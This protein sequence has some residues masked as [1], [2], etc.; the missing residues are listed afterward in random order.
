MVVYFQNKTFSIIISFLYGIVL[1]GCNPHDLGST[2]IKGNI[3]FPSADKIYFYSFADSTDIFLENKVAMDSSVIDKNKNYSFSFQLK[4][5]C[6]F[7]LIIGNKNLAT[8]LFISPGDKI[9]INFSGKNN[10]SEI[11]SSGDAGKYNTYLIKYLDAFYKNPKTKEEYYI[12]TNYMDIHHFVLY[13]ESRK[14]EQLVFFNNFFANDE[15]KKDFRDYALNT[16]N[17]GIAVDRLMYLWKKRMKGETVIA[18]SS[19]FSFATPEFIENKSAFNC[20]AYI[21]FLNLY[22][23]DTYERMVDNGELPHDKSTRLIP[24]VE[25]YKL[26][27]RILH[28]PF[29]DVVLFNI[30]FSD[31]HNVTEKNISHALPEIALDSMIVRFNKKYSLN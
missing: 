29:R 23:K 16:I 3:P 26:A 28:K 9:T 13:N 10:E 8:N 12:G 22:I 14:Q 20:P 11:I 17:Y 31:M 24:A 15:L 1:S 21:R 6:V 5:S 19:Y 25:K 4:N 2:I 7:D 30:I 27:L 18:D